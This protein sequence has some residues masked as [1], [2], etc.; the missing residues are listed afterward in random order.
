MIDDLNP[1][2]R[3]SMWLGCLS[4][5]LICGFVYAWFATL[6]GQQLAS[7]GLGFVAIIVVSVALLIAFCVACSFKYVRHGKVVVYGT[8]PHFHIYRQG[9]FYNNI[10]ST[11]TNTAT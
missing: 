3:I 6:F 2:E 7:Q 8:S 9:D 4:L 10:F 11:R 1:K 5:V